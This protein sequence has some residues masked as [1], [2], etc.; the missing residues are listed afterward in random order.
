MITYISNPHSKTSKSQTKL[1]ETNLFNVVLFDS[2]YSKTCNWLK[3]ELWRGLLE[4]KQWRKWNT[5]K[6]LIKKITNIYTYVDIHVCLSLL[7]M[8]SILK[9]WTLKA[10]LM[11]RNSSTLCRCHCHCKFPLATEKMLQWHGILSRNLEAQL[12]QCLPLRGSRGLASLASQES[13]WNRID[14]ILREKSL[15]YS[16][17]LN[18]INARFCFDLL[19]F[20]YFCLQ[21][22]RV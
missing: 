10:E 1:K 14:N 6:K 22:L 5:R 13:T 3:Y 9:V 15:N 4:T 17:D 12:F 20:T 7:V 16:H 21:S 11:R 18:G 8:L 2:T 19:F